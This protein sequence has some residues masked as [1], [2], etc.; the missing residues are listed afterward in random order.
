MFKCRRLAMAMAVG[1]A[2]PP[3]VTTTTSP[4]RHTFDVPTTSNACKK[5]ITPRRRK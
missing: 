4:A 2:S 3:H 1:G 5:K